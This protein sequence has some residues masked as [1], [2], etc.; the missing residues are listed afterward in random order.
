V[1]KN[2]EP[3]KK[4]VVAETIARKEEEKGRR[5]RRRGVWVGMEARREGGFL[6]GATKDL[7]RLEGVFS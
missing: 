3:A 1:E 2:S 7:G 4:Q 5:R 6:K